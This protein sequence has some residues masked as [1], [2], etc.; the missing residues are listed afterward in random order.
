M[1]V[2]QMAVLIGAAGAMLIAGCDG[3]RAPAQ[4]EG[5]GGRGAGGQP[6]P[7]SDPR[8]GPAVPAATAPADGPDAGAATSGSGALI[9][10]APGEVGG[11]PDDRIPLAERNANVTPSGPHSPQ[12]AANVVQRYAALIEQRKFDAAFA[13]WETDSA[14]MSRAE[15]ARSFDKYSEIHT[16]V[17]GPGLSDGAAGSIFIEVPMQIYGRLKDGGTFNLIGP[18]T[19]GRVN[20]VPGATEAQLT[21]RIRQS[22]LRP[23]GVVRVAP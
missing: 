8:D 23:R 22:E 16:L 4:G 15:F 11:L 5:G 7:A 6:A 20:D 10:P 17:G 3:A 9:P 14:G 18:V 1:R 21:W 19:L 2:E 13:L 12:G